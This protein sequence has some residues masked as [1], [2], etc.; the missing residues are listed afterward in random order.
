M[1]HFG[2]R[3]LGEERFREQ[4]KQEKG[5]AAFGPRVRD[6]DLA[7]PAPT[8][9]A[10][11]PGAATKHGPALAPSGEDGLSIEQFAKTLDDNAAFLDTL[12]IQELERPGGPRRECLLKARQVAIAL[13]NRADLVAEIDGFLADIAPKGTAHAPPTSA[14]EDR[15]RQIAKVEA[16]DDFAALK[17]LCEKLGLDRPVSKAA[18]KKALIE[19]I[20]SG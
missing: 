14:A 16:L 13:N 7:H 18:A 19:K 5:G 11:A 17:A 12:Y 9:V 15:H 4:V 3:I 10:Q 1:P 6:V 2:P 8:S 20:T